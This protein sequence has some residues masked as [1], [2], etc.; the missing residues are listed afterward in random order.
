MLP[1][2]THRKWAREYLARA[3][4]AQTRNDQIRLLQMAVK[5]TVRAQEL[6]SHSAGDGVN[7]LSL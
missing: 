3:Q 7:D 2:A 5:Y 6:E 1:A 4:E